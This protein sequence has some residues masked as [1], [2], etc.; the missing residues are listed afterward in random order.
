MRLRCLFGHDFGP[1]ELEREREEQGDEVVVTLR[2]TRTCRR[3]DEVQVVSENKEVTSIAA[4]DPEM[5]E[6]ETD[7]EAEPDA[8]PEPE[9]ESAAGET[10]DADDGV[11]M[12]PDTAASPEPA[13]DEPETPE[14]FDADPPASETEDAEVLTDD[15][16]AEPE[17]AETGDTDESDAGEGQTP[18]P[19][20]TADVSDGPSA[21]EDDGIILADDDG[22]SGRQRGEWPASDD[23]D[24]D[25]GDRNIPSLSEVEAEAAA[26]GR[27]DAEPPT[28][29][30][31]A[32]DAGDEPEHAPWPEQQGEDEGFA[33][34]KSDDTATDVE[35]GGGLAPKTEP[36]PP[37]EDATDA[38]EESVEE[39]IEQR[40]RGRGKRGP[41]PGEMTSGDLE[42][43]GDVT[44]EF[45]CP[46]CGLSEDAVG[47]S[48]REGDICP[49]CHKDYIAERSGD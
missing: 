30:E 19:A 26:E 42:V 7:A 44:R 2:E 47:S 34:G 14:S 38:D 12:Q 5:A 21:D 11:T 32:G 43:S 48:L 15:A 39:V 6:D 10:P 22:D 18:Q 4:I 40:E 45:Y 29:E 16:D 49:E 17:V 24:H 33:A 1:P 28:D 35:F 31:Q 13:H 3:C 23:V 20:S 37:G 46:S 27:F 36:T 41:A 9:P 25:D 8:E